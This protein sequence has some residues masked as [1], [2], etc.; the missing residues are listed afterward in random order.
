MRR[1][2]LPSRDWR[3]RIED[4]LESVAKIERYTEGMSLENLRDDE[5]TVD[6][7]VRNLEIIGEAARHV[8]PY[9]QERHC[10]ILWAQMRGMRNVVIHEY[11]EISLPVIWD[12]IK[13]D[14]PPLVPM[15]QAILKREV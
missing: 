4:I 6:A 5:R 11:S 13:V 3:L 7:V 12:T 1:P 8:P 10:Q 15:L 14:L 9:I 2:S